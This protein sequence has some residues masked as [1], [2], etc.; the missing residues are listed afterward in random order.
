MN[1]NAIYANFKDQ[2][3]AV[4][5]FI[6]LQS[7]RSAILVAGTAYQGIVLDTAAPALAGVAGEGP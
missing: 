1:F 4:T 5:K 2:K 6:K 3:Q 7:I